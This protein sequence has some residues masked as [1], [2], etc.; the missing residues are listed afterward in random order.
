MPSVGFEPMIP[1]IKWLQAYAL[2]H[3][4][5]GMSISLIGCSLFDNSVHCLDCITEMNRMPD[6]KWEKELL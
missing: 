1:G 5:T 2:D 6:D 4:A 3:T